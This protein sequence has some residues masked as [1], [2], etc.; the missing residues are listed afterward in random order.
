[1]RQSVKTITTVHLY[2]QPEDMDVIMAIAKEYG[3]A[4][5]ENT[6]Q[7]HGATYQGKK[8]GCSI[9]DAGCF[10][11]YP[12]K[13]LGAYGEAGAIVI[14]N[15]ALSETMRMFREHRQAKKNYNTMVV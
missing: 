15:E 2:G 13:N 8:A 5:I 1:M 3:L 14:N 10:S 7:A 11:F 9:G 12:G 6:C 4:V